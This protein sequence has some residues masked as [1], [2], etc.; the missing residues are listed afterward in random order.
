M[1]SPFA[2][3]SSASLI[4]NLLRRA[5]TV[6]ADAGTVA[7]R[8]V[9]RARRVVVVMMVAMVMMAVLVVV[10]LDRSRGRGDFLPVVVLGIGLCDE[11]HCVTDDARLSRVWFGDCV[12]RATV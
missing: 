6:E 12:S 1:Q 4:D 9:A 10:A 5:Q 3:A 11:T 7:V 2:T 8:G